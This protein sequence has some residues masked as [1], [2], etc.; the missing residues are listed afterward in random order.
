MRSA[1]LSGFP[2]AAARG[3]ASP[4]AHCSP[5]GG[6]PGAEPRA[7]PQNAKGRKGGS[8]G[9]PRPAREEARRAQGPEAG[10]GASPRHAAGSSMGA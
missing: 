10:L 8:S 9:F 2:D 5:R 6:A 1:L 3:T 7:A 4:R